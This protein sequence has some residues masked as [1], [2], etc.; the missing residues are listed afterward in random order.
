MPPLLTQALLELPL[1]I[2][3]ALAKAQ[4]QRPGED[5]AE[6]ARLKML[7]MATERGWLAEDGSLCCRN[8]GCWFITARKPA[9]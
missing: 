1:P 8:N 4:A 9:A 7:H 6:E 5:V 3:P 2:K